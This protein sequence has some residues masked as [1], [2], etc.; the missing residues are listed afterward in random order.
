M[1]G[2]ES[3]IDWPQ[4]MKGG[5]LGPELNG[6]RDLL[7]LNPTLIIMSPAPTAAIVII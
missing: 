2:K 5:P 3:R 6:K 1:V 7:I 4:A